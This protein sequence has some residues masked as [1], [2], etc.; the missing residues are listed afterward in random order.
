MEKLL[1]TAEEAGAILGVGRS[2]IYDLMRTRQLHSVRIGKSRRI[3][4][5]AVQAFVNQLTEG[6]A[7]R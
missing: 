3:P 1:L 6:E 7:T 5:S 2:R 4:A